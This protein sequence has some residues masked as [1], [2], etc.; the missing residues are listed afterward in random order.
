LSLRR[1][2]LNGRN[3]ARVLTRFPFMTL[4]VIAAIHWEA[5]RLLL[6]RIP[7]FSHPPASGKPV[8]N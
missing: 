2:P 6:K 1:Q 7:V 8:E 4:K 5:L 3:L